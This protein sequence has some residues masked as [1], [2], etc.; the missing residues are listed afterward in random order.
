MARL[1]YLFFLVLLAA[2][3]F[4][5]SE[6]KNEQY[7]IS[8][9]GRD[10]TKLKLT[11][12]NEHFYGEYIHTRGGSQREKGQFSG[13]VQGDI[14]L[15]DNLYTPYRWKEKKRVPIALK[16]QGENLLEGSGKMIEFM[17]ILSY[18][19]R[20]IDFHSPKRVFKLSKG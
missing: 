5:S 6:H 2:C 11:I 3:S 12:I 7:Y 14:L 4:S 20:T 8:V 10:T 9:E 19:P 1:F 18:H 15:G 16:L 17:G 13:K